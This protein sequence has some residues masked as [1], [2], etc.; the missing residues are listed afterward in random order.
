MLAKRQKKKKKKE[1]CLGTSEMGHK[2]SSQSLLGSCPKRPRKPG[3]AEEGGRFGRE[4]H[5]L[6]EM[7]N[8]GLGKGE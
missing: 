7:L 6:C 1:N 3:A 5:A 8:A 2:D 4:G